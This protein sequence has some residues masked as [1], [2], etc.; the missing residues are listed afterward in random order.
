VTIFDHIASALSAGASEVGALD[1]RFLLPALALQLGNLLF[2]SLL[3]RNV[4]AAAYPDRRVPT[5]FVSAA[6]AAGA[7]LNAF[8]PARGGDLAK[9]LFVRTRIA[10]STLATI[11]A[12]LSV[13]LI[14]DG[15]IAI[16]LVATLWALGILPALPTLPALDP[17]WLA[18]AGAAVLA[19]AVSFRL[20]PGL[21]RSVLAHL[22]RGLAILRAP[23]R[24]LVTVV[25]F[26]F[27]A[28][29]CRIGVVFLVL[30]AFHI[31]VSLTT[32]AL[33]VVLNGLSTAAP[34]PG[35]AGTQQVLAAY[36]LHG[37]APVAQAVTFS[38]SMQLGV[39]IV[40]TAVGMVAMMLLLGT[41]RPLAAARSSLTLV[42]LERNR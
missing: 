28:W 35:G 14:L 41:Y 19:V 22:A 37:V 12:S 15:A 30:A 4:L 26:Q 1:G 39:T 8:V 20:K 3:W 11:A 23:R 33:I 13:V 18:L 10:G 31:H 2:R 21:V 42:R 32:A 24:Y 25:P 17:R 38:L 6:Y 9:L 29:A 16:V 34:V 27:A 5:I 40:N 7:A 36:A